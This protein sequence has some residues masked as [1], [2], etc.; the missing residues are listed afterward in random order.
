MQKINQ[1]DVSFQFGEQGFKTYFKEDKYE[2]GLMVLPFEGESGVYINKADDEIIICVF[3]GMAT[4]R[5][6][7][8]F[9]SI[10]EGEALKVEAGEMY[11]VICSTD[12][13]RA[14]YLKRKK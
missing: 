9:V 12:E 8:A 5:V 1:A 2:F 3:Y 13:L 4:V 10:N 11:N 14:I 6:N 7:D